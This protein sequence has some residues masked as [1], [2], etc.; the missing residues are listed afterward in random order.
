MR[1]T[2]CSLALTLIFPL[3]FLAPL[4]PK[5]AYSAKQPQLSPKQ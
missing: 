1:V 3:A 4:K 2:L 5:E